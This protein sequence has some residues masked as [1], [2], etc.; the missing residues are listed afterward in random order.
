[1]FLGG[2]VVFSAHLLGLQ[3]HTGRVESRLVRRNGRQLFP[4]QELTGTGS[5]PEGHMQVV[6]W[7]RVHI[8]PCP[9]RGLPQLLAAIKSCFKGSVLEYYYTHVLAVI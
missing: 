9:A 4:R 2:H 5:R 6:H 1:M 8:L 3:I 7:L